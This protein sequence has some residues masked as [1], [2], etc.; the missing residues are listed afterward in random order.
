MAGLAWGAT[1]KFWDASTWSMPEYALWSVVILLGLELMS[2]LVNEIP[3]RFFNPSAIPIRGKHLD[4]LSWKDISFIT[5]NKFTTTL[6]TYH[7]LRFC[8]LSP[9]IAW[10]S[11]RL[12]DRLSGH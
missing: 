12:A 8:W 5:W 4:V 2:Y 1:F 9:R 11:A 6:F 10:V 7:A 3:Q